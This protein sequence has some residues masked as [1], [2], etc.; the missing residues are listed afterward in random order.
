MTSLALGEARRSVRLLLTKNHPVS[1]S[2]FSRRDSGNPL[3]SPQFLGVE[4]LTKKANR[5]FTKTRKKRSNT[6]PD[7]GIEPETPCQVVALTTTLLTRQSSANCCV[8]IG[9]NEYYLSS[10]VRVNGLLL[11]RQSL[12]FSDI[13]VILVGE[14]VH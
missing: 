8:E 2:C 11:H 13:T 4:I 7:P 9:Y 10:I 3:G 5:K 12:E 6:W 14:V 1:Y